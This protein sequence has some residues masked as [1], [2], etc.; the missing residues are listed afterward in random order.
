MTSGVLRLTRNDRRELGVD[1][2]HF[3]TVVKTAFGQRRKTLRN[4]LSSLP[5]AADCELLRGPMGAQ[6][7]ERLGVEDFILLAKAL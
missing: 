2:K 4:S 5:G 6:R 3:R 7:P 1:E